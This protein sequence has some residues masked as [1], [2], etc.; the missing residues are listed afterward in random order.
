M[1]L[2][3]IPKPFK[4]SW[5]FLATVLGSAPA[6]ISAKPLLTTSLISGFK[7]NRASDTRLDPAITSA[8]PL[9]AIPPTK[10][11]SKVLPEKSRDLS[12]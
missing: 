10:P 6:S 3:S 2:S 8:T 1:F 9:P 12:P 5:I 7:A 11:F 4:L